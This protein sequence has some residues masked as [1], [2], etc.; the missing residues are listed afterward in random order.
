MSKGGSQFPGET[1]IRS[2]LELFFSE[3]WILKSSRTYWNELQW[4]VLLQGNILL[5]T[6]S[7]WIT[8]QCRDEWHNLLYSQERG[9]GPVLLELAKGTAWDSSF[10][11]IAEWKTTKPQQWKTKA[12][13]CVSPL[14]RGGVPQS[15]VPSV[16]ADVW[17][18]HSPAVIPGRQTLVEHS[19]CS[20]ECQSPF[21][22]CL[23]WKLGSYSRLE[24]C[25][26]SVG[27]LWREKWLI[28]G[29]LCH[30]AVNS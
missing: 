27:G 13:A 15:T 22:R 6:R 23:E 17:S 7:L 3:Q 2:L 28:R 10:W 14:P 21:W 4:L 24:D 11:W 9:M 25:V 12:T 20:A 30:S 5:Y 26:L 1:F 8:A 29:A 19:Y 16:N 18:C